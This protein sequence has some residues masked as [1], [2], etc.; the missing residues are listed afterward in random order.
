M[1]LNIAICDDNQ[2]YI[3]ILEKYILDKNEPD[4]S[5]DAFYSGEELVKMYN[6][7]EGNYDVIFLDIHL[8]TK[9]DGMAI[10]EQLRSAEISS[11]MIFVTSLENRAIDGYDVGA[12]GFV[13]KK[14]LDEKL[15]KVLTKLWKDHFYRP[16]ILIQGKEDT[17]II[18]LNHII[19]VQSQ[20]RSTIIQ[21]DTAE[22]TD[23][24]PIGKFAELLGDD[25]VEV[26]KSV[27]VN[28]SKIKRINTDTVTMCDES[29]VPLSRRNR[30]NVMFAVMKQIGDK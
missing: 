24:R 30:K 1:E 2:E 25:F 22:L 8:G 26:H 27:F 12:Y 17:E 28:I 20:N 11:P 10:A 16:T 18:K 9:M 3:N 23:I 4:V 6:M 21:T 13:V 7:G 15:P 29:N 14:N 5:C 19:S